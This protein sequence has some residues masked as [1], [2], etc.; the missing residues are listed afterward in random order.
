MKILSDW[1]TEGC[2]TGGYCHWANVNP[3]HKGDLINAVLADGGQKDGDGYT[4]INLPLGHATAIF[5]SGTDEYY[6]VMND[7]D[8]QNYCNIGGLC[9]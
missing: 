1:K 7:N 3:A 8:W 4:N 2:S 6:V 5:L 9:W